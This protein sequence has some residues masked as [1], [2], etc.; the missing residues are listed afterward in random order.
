MLP[1]E[2]GVGCRCSTGR[3]GEVA[4]PAHCSCQCDAEKG[5][6]CAR[7][8]ETELGNTLGRI[9]GRCEVDQLLSPKTRAKVILP[10]LTAQCRAW[11]K[12]S[13]G[14]SS[15]ETHC[16]CHWKKKTGVG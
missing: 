6:A 16:V 3:C 11:V 12:H 7:R 14:A 5:E 2:L 15:V 13:N 10:V 4:R 9:C 8:G 1:V